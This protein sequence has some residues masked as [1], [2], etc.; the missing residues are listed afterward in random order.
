VDTQGQLLALYV[1]PA[2][3]QDRAQVAE[4]A[5]AVQDATGETVT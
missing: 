1:T 4:L 3:E 2:T 5:A